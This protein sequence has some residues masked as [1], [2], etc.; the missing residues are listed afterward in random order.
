MGGGSEMRPPANR[1]TLG[2]FKARH[3]GAKKGHGLLKKKRDALKARFMGMLKEIVELKIGVARGL[4][5]CSFSMAKAVW[6]SDANLNAAILE[7]ASI[8]SVTCALTSHN[9]AGV[10]LPIFKMNHDEKLD[11]NIHTI[12]CGQGGAV[13]GKTREQNFAVLELLVRMASMQTSFLTLD[14]EIQMTGRRVNALEYIIIPAIEDVISYI[15]LELDEQARE[16][17]TRVKKVVQKKKDWAL[18]EKEM[19]ARDSATLAASAIAPK[20]PDVVF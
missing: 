18:K 3:I 1:M 14:I 10:H 16:E 17:F 8:P 2:V 20:D 11:G 5:E 19:D 4:K 9:I 13:I 7:R 15:K 6:A 12:G